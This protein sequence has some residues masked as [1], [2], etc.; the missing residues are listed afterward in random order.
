[1]SARRVVVV[2]GGMVG[3][4]LAEEL[5]ARADGAT[6]VTVVGAEPHEPYNRV[7]LSE[8]VGGAVDP[9][10]VWLPAAPSARVRRGVRVTA[11]DRGRRL[12]HCDDGSTVGYDALVLATGARARIPATPGLVDGAGQLARG[13]YALR[14]LDD[15]R[16]V[17]DAARHRPA[18]VVLGGGVLGIEVATGL[19]ARGLA[20]TVVH[21]GPHLMDRQLDAVGASALAVA[22]GRLGIA[23]RAGA[24]V[25]A[26]R[27]GEEGVRG[28][29]LADGERIACGLL[30]VSAGAVP[31]T[32]LAS[33]AGLAVGRGILVDAAL[34]TSD[35]AVFAV[36]DCAEPPEGCTGLVA[37]GWAQARRLA[38]ALAG[39]P[40]AAATDATADDPVDVVRVKA[41]GVAVAAM[42]AADAGLLPGARR[43]ML[44]EEGGTRHVSVVVR[45]GVLVGATCVGDAAVAA[46]LT[47]TYTRRTPVPRDPATLLLRPVP[48]A[49]P[50][51]ASSPTRMPDRATVCRCNGVAKGDVVAS[52]RAGARSV[53]EVVRATRA[54]TGCGGCADLV[55]GLVDWLERADPDPA[56][57]ERPDL[58]VPASA[59]CGRVFAAE[60]PVA[61]G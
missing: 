15:A 23:V 19:A 24:R 2:G 41:H 49:V 39:G 30:V 38:A 48:G 35:P 45:D 58:T 25:G 42:G 18:A 47:A 1:M 37:Q 5:A 44:A 21:G 51:E 22:L 50:V 34:A 52:W 43:L 56:G 60:T 46:D 33:A 26:V 4:R 36:G 7:L 57:A 9:D 54:T 53:P 14:T 16:A 61:A 6:R 31:E 13:A 17:A 29:E 40:R 32:A 10:S 55:A 28:V 12:V 3:A 11:V 20:V 59:P 8:V 27:S